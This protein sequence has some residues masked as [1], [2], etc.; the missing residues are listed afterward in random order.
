MCYLGNMLYYDHTFYLKLA[1]DFAR[2]VFIKKEMQLGSL[3]VCRML[4]TTEIIYISGV[5]PEDKMYY[6]HRHSSLSS[7]KE[8]VPSVDTIACVDYRSPLDV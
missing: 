8:E 4:L 6:I 1:E 2:P 5:G 7:S 3:I